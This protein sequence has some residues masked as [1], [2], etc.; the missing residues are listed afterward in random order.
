[1]FL[2]RGAALRYPQRVATSVQGPVPSWRPGQVLS[3][4][5]RTKLVVLGGLGSRTGD[6]ERSFAGL[7][8][9]LA[10]EAGYDRGRDVL[11][12]SYA[13]RDVDGRW[14][15]RPFGP[16]DTKKSLLDAAEAVAG[17]L[18]WYRD[19]LP[20]ARF[21]LLGYSLGGVSL[22]D[23]LAMALVRDREGW[24]GRVGAV[25]TLASPLRGCNAGPFI[26]WAWVAT[27]DP[28]PLGAVGADLD[29]RWTD[30]QERA[31]VER[32]AAFIRSHGVRLLT[33]A[34]PDDAVVRPDEAVLPA[35]GET[36]DALMVRPR[37]GR[38]GSYGHGGILDDRETWRRVLQ[39][40][41]PQQ[42]D[43]DSAVGGI[44]PIELELEAIKA[45]LRASGRLPAT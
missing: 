20:F 18:E 26:Q 37:W 41:G 35:P 6:A 39:V 16:Q 32:R 43:G 10:R 5:G 14:Q 25:V 9:Y 3:P 27:L 1:M 33:L 4:V 12:A 24:R 40:V 45:R 23:G 13:G 36:E 8:H 42:V 15:P 19:A 7:G 29:R 11:E 38:P 22:L 44:D 21:C 30:T 2:H 28:D 31:R 34:D 17:V